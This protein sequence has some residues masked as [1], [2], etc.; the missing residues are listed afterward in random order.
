MRECKYEL[1]MNKKS[2]WLKV[3]RSL[4][5][6]RSLYFEINPL[7]GTDICNRKAEQKSP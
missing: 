6:Q 1:F 5:S 3:P 2:G 4:L 7:Q